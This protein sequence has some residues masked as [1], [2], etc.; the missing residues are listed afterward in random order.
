LLYLNCPFIF[1][2]ANIEVNLILGNF[3]ASAF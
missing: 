3:G 2:K 1:Q